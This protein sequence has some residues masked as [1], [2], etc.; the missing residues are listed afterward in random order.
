MTKII[1]ISAIVIVSASAVAFSMAF[2]INHG[3][4]AVT[5]LTAAWDGG[6]GG[7]GGCCG[8]SGNGGNEVT[9]SPEPGPTLDN[10]GFENSGSNDNAPSGDPNPPTPLAAPTC[11]LNA[12]VLTVTQGGSATLTWSTTN[13]TSVTLTSFG[14]VGATGSQSVTPGTTTTYTLTVIGPDG[15]ES[16]AVTVTV[17][18]P[19]TPAP[20]CTFTVSPTSIQSGGAATLSW[21]TS[22]ATAVSINQNIGTVNTSGSQSVTP[23][24]TTTYTLTATGNGQTV[25]C[26]QTVAVT[27]VPLPTAF[28][29]QN[30]VTFSA[31]PTT[32]NRGASTVLSWSVTGATS[33]AIDN[34][35][36]ST[37]QSSGSATVQPNQSTTYT[38]TA[39]NGTTTISCPLAV[40]VDQ[41]GGGGGGGGGGSATPRCEL[42]ASDKTIRAGE[43]VTLR[44]DTSNA[45]LVEIK[46]SRDTIVVTTEG[47]LGSAK[48]DLYDGSITVRPTRDT[49][50]T[51]TA[52]RGSRDRECTVKIDVADARVTEVREQPLVQSIALSDVPHTG[53]DAKSVVQYTLLASIVLWGIYLAY[54]FRRREQ[55][56]SEKR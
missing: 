30:N 50:Y 19:T 46:D 4:Q 48:K 24:T 55:V 39:G 51:L 33:V 49:T 5:S 2:D 12:S 9:S 47:L 25:T 34:G 45:T 38:L 52:A 14:S 44:W 13:G 43:R 1:Q 15:T 35:V 32:I 11:T 37:N 8:D 56:V 54:A 27:S 6:T 29:C 23:G 22:N 7:E 31:N 20:V 3:T 36:M 10:N 21:T 28:T 26:T 42:T 40:T 17:T 41:G 18:P 53:V 16:C